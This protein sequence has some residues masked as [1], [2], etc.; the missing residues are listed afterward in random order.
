LSSATENG[1]LEVASLPSPLMMILE[2][3]FLLSMS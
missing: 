3:G 1:S 2:N